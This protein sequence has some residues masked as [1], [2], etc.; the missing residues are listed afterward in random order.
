VSSP[1]VPISLLSPG[2]LG[3]NTQDAKV[4]L[5]SGYATKANNCIID[6]YG[7]LGSRKGYISLTSNPGTLTADAYI[8]SIYEFTD[9][10]GETYVLSAG[11]GKLFSGTTTLVP[12]RPKLAD[13]TT[14][15]AGTFTNNRWQFCSGAVGSGT[16]AL[17]SGIATQKGNAALVWRRTSGA[18]AYIFQEIGVYGTKPSGVATFDPDCCLSAF[19]RVWTAGISANKHT[20][21]FSDLL[22]PTNFS[23]GT[24]GILDISTVVGNNDEIVGLAQHNNFLVIFCTNSIVVYGSQGTSAVAGINPLTMQ[25]VDVVTGV[26]CVSRDSIQ[27]TG[28]DLIYLSKSGIRSLNRTVTENSMPMRELSLNIR[29]DVTNYLGLEPNTDNIKSGYFEKEAFYIL[30]F[31]SSRIM[32]YV[33]LRTAL[34]NG[35]A[36][37]TTWSLDN[38]D[39]YKAFTATETRKFYFGVP[40]GIGEYSGYVDN[41]ESYEMTY[42]SPFADVTG[43][44][45]KKFLKK[46]KLLVIGSGEQDFTFKYGYNYTLNPRT[47]V[48]ARDL[49]TGI[50]AKWS[51]LTSLYAV[52]KYSSVGLGV[53]EIRVPLGGSG[54]TFAFGV[55]A[56]IDTAALSIQKIDL[57][58]KTGKNS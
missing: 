27:A 8:E 3:L 47:V 11:D 48:L 58:L 19:G 24:A 26:G 15:V 6:Q 45:V 50:Y 12:H 42:R 35:S 54:D 41:N 1:L 5:D 33:D 10:L 51:S 21:F 34:P 31:P 53:Q 29:D 52:S 37:V 56:T 40:N 13:Q 14:D 43:G 55:D 9:N 30:T 17:V 49:G 16:S 36:R 20:I 22:D 2:F 7:R 23:T 57:F 44:V 4:G 39:V 28:T 32:I 25:L 38:G 46:A 18:G